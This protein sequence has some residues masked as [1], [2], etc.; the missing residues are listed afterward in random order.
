MSCT[1]RGY[2]PTTVFDLWHPVG[3]PRGRLLLGGVATSTAPSNDEICE[4]VIVAPTEAEASRAWLLAAVQTAALRLSTAGLVWVIVTPSWRQQ[5][6]S[7]LRRNGLAIRGVVLMTP[8]W[9]DSQH[10]LPLA[11][12][13]VRDALTRHLHRSP[14]MASIGGAIVETKIGRLLARRRA[15]GCALLASRRAD[16]S[17]FDWLNRVDGRTA[18]TPLVS[19]SPR[20]DARVAVVLRFPARE[21]PDLAIK[22]GLDAAGRERVNAERRS[23]GLLGPA[24]RAAGAEVPTLVPDRTGPAWRLVTSALDGIP[25]ATVLAV[26]PDRCEAILSRLADWLLAWNR[27][28]QATT[29]AGSEMLDQTL[30]RPVRDLAAAGKASPA[31][32]AAMHHLADDLSGEPINSVATHNDLTMANVIVKQKGLGVVDWESAQATGLPLSDLFYALADCTARALR[33]NP[34]RA[35]V[36]QLSQRGSGASVT[37]PDLI[38]EHARALR[39]TE[40]QTR[41]AFH[42]CWLRHASEELRRGQ[43]RG[44]FLDVLSAITTGKT[45]WGEPRPG[46]R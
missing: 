26:S 17:L 9:P 44:P 3:V 10:L 40:P 2:E 11:G 7:A 43:A 21:P 33:S 6:E 38:G 18:C 36:Q 15:P 24:A 13:I 27:A 8:P 25:A 34:A 32:L 22:V 45:L 12:P 37:L 28:T 42:T 16:P 20:P 23:L 35:I 30:L 5:A 39:L 14:A 31:Y 4:Q 29:T 19:R 41:L 46:R 1:N